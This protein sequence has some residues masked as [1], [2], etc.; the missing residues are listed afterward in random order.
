VKHLTYPN[1]QDDEKTRNRP[2]LLGLQDRVIFVNHDHPEV[3]AKELA[4]RRDE[5]APSSKRNAFEVSLVLKVVRYLG[6][7]GY[8]TDRVVI[9]TPYLGQLRLLRDEL[10]KTNDPVLNDLD[11][12][13]LIRAG[14]LSETG[15][16]VGKRSIKISTIGKLG[17]P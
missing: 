2:A 16:N 4:D 15:A 14:L 7:Q 11:S 17:I 12:F 5:G 1:L 6:Q 3:D 9:L 8:G 13:D 10:S